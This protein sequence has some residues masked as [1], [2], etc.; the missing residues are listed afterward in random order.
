[1][2]GPNWIMLMNYALIAIVITAWGGLLVCIGWEVA[3]RAALKERGLGGVRSAFSAL[4]ATDAHRIHIPELGMTMADGG[5]ELKP[6][7]PKA[8]GKKSRTE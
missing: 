3:K 1:M 5:E 8:N 7:D 4:L 2:N 6:S